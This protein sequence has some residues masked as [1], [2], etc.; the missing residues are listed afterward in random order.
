[1]L[2]YIFTFFL[3]TLTTGCSIMTH[4]DSNSSHDSQQY[5]QQQLQPMVNA[6]D[7]E[8]VDEITRLAKSG[9][10]VNTRGSVHQQDRLVQWTYLNY[11]VEKGKLKSAQRLID[12]GADVNGLLIDGSAYSSNMNIA[13]ANGDRNMINLLL[14]NNINLNND[15]TF[16]P[17]Y[18]L[19]IYEH[20]DLALFDLLI[21]HGADVNHS[22]YIG[23]RT[24]LMTAY[25]INKPNIIDYLLA[26]RANPLQIDYN[27]NSFASIIG[28]NINKGK[29]L[30]ISKKYQQILIIQHGV[31]YPIKP[32]FR[33]GLEASIKR[34]ENTTA[35]EK[36]LLGQAEVERIEYYRTALRK[37]NLDGI[38]L[39]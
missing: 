17:I 14:K 3:I 16:S 15:L 36:Q 30:E 4:S 29:K 18:D 37:G 8:D 27:G 13:C 24:L 12:L 6:I 32:S 34:Y 25:A 31:K 39:D 21:K 38:P 22:D 23:G 20:D 1:M 7:R 28:S 9:Y 2:K 35:K 33:K 5:F 19:M 11:A 26:K 10:D